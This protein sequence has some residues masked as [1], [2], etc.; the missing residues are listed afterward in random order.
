MG[1]QQITDEQLVMQYHETGSLSIL[2]ELFVRYLQKIRGLVYSMVLHEADADDITQE[3]F[4]RAAR[5]IGRFKIRSRFSTW[6]YRI[7]MN[8][9]KSHLKRKQGVP[10]YAVDLDVDGV[11]GGV[12]RPDSRLL[13]EECN[14]RI[15]DA[16]RGLSPALRSAIILTVIHD[17]SIAE[18]AKIERCSRAAMHW[19]VHTARRKLYPLLR[20]GEP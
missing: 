16:L 12:L 13:T 2:D 14:Q 1:E 4:A 10:E 20:E 9:V 18:A 11:D 3:I 5:A 15:E 7:A 17:R 19:R 8:T 6:L